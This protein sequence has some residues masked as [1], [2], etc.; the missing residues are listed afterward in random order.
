MGKPAPTTNAGGDATEWNKVDRP[1]LITALKQ[2]GSY[3]IW[4]LGEHNYVT[5]INTDGGNTEG[6]NL[7]TSISYQ[8]NFS[9]AVFV[10]HTSVQDLT[11][12]G[13]Y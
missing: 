9:E 13:P 6:N 1:I 7:T 11:Y 12:D 8:N 3:F 10:K 4:D 2:N 5:V